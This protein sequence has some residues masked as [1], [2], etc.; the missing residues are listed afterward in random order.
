[1]NISFRQ[2]RAFV[3]VARLGNLGAAAD[4]LCLTRGAISQALK[5]LETQLGTPLFDRAH[6][7]PAAA[8]AVEGGGQVRVLA[9]AQRLRQRSGKGTAA[10]HQGQTLTG[11]SDRE[12]HT[13]NTLQ[14]RWG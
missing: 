1:M 4:Q 11:W 10:G 8:V 13:S 5:E 12:G 2:L 7:G 9:I 3:A 14:P 6:P